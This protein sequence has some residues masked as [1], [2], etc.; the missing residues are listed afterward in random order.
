MNYSITMLDECQHFFE[1]WDKYFR[2]SVG[3]ALQEVLIPWKKTLNGGV[4]FNG[5]NGIRELK[6]DQFTMFFSVL[7]VHMV[8]SHGC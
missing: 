5:I 3:V 6:S 1:K 2:M 4:S 7:M 8:R